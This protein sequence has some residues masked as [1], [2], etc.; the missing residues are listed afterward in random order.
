[1]HWYSIV[2]ILDP[3]ASVH[4]TKTW[5]KIIFS[6][7]TL[8]SKEIK[9]KLPA[10]FGGGEL[11]KTEFS[12]VCFFLSYICSI[13]YTKLFPAISSYHCYLWGFEYRSAVIWCHKHPEEQ[14]CT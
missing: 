9:R 8:A 4:H 3:K 1:M 13:A 11:L 2:Q 6:C 12:K 5:L 7:S 14:T 10:F